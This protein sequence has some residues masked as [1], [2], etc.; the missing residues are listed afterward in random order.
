MTFKVAVKGSAKSQFGKAAFRLYAGQGTTIVVHV[1]ISNMGDDL[2]LVRDLADYDAAF[3]EDL[4]KVL[5]GQ[6]VPQ[7]SVDRQQD[8]IPPPAPNLDDLSMQQCH[9]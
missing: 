1:S 5:V 8:H 3:G 9:S 2:G 7:V 6:A 4:L